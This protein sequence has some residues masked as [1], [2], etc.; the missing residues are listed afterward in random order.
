QDINA[1]LGRRRARSGTVSVCISVMGTNLPF[2][3]HAANGSYPANS[4]H[5]NRA[6]HGSG[7]GQSW[8]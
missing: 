1:F 7:N 8:P 6:D 3:G 4:G 5:R 2:V